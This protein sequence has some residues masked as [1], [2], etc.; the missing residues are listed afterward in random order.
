MHQGTQ[1]VFVTTADFAGD[2]RR[3][4]HLLGMVVGGRHFRVVQE[5]EP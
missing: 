1:E 4:Q 3:T 2:D 5:Q